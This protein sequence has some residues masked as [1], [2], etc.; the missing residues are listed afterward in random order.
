[1]EFKERYPDL[2]NLAAVDDILKRFQIRHGGTQRNIFLYLSIFECK[3]HFVYGGLYKGLTL[4]TLI[5][6]LE[7]FQPKV[8]CFENYL[9]AKND[10]NEING[11]KEELMPVL[12]KADKCLKNFSFFEKDFHNGWKFLEDVDFLLL[13]GPAAVTDM[14]PFADEFP[15]ILHD[16]N[17]H[18][19]L[20]EPD[21]THFSPIIR[22][23]DYELSPQFRLIDEAYLHYF[24]WMD[25]SRDA[26][27]G[28]YGGI[29]GT[30]SA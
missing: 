1:M 22:D 13:D 2:S 27:W 28:G 9:C 18:L 21:L 6:F 20:P 15:Y 7:V 26:E 29:Y 12:D 24:H 17:Y 19:S 4:N 10:P 16:I 25:E 14:T 8:T 11:V 3:Q 30:K 5:P 23:Y